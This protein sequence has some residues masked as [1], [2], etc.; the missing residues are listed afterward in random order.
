MRV[1]ETFGVMNIAEKIEV[2]PLVVRV[3][4]DKVGATLSIADEENIGIQYTIPIDE[5]LR[6]LKREKKL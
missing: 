3:T 6:D 1:Y 5:I 2:I 4:V